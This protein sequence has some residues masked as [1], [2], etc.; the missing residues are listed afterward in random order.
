MRVRE[1]TSL[2]IMHNIMVDENKKQGH[3]KE[4]SCKTLKFGAD[5]DFLQG[6]WL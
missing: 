6:G 3:K 1:K 4:Q 2:D 5:L